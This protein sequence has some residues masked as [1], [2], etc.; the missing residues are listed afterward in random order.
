MIGD[1]ASSPTGRL[2]PGMDTALNPT[3][4]R[5]LALCRMDRTWVRGAGVWVWDAHG[6]RFL[7]C[8]AQYGAVALGHNAP[9]VVAAV[10]A[11]LDEG[12]PAMVQPYRAAHA[13][14][15]ADELARL[16]PGGLTRCLFTTSGAEAVE[17]AIQLVRARTGRPLVLSA[18]GSFHG[19]T[20]GALAASG[21]L[22]G[23]EGLGPLPPG[24]GRVPFGDA[25]ALA[26]RLER[27]GPRVAALLLEPIQG[28]R[29]VYLP[30]PGYLRAARDLCTRHGAALVLDE[31]QTGL[32]RTGKLFACEHEGV[33]PDVLLLSKALGGGLFPLGACLA[34]PA[35]WDEPFA[36][37]HSSTFAN[38]NVACRVGRAVL[39]ALT[40]GGLAAEAARKGKRLEDRLQELADRYPSVVA[41]A[42][43]RG[44]LGAIELRPVRPGQGTFLSFL[45]HQGLYAYAVAAAI[46]EIASVLVLPTLGRVPV[47]RV[48]PP[49][50]IGD[51]ELEQAVDGIEEVCRRLERNAP[52][53]LVRILGSTA[54]SGDPGEGAKVA[55]V[56]PPPPTRPAPEGP[57]YAFLV[58]PTRPG[59][60]ALTNPGLERLGPAELE[61][62]WGFLAQVPPG[63]VLRAPPVRSATGRVAHGWLILVPLLP[64]EMARRGLKS[65]SRQIAEAVDLA[66]CCGA[67]VV[68]LGGHTT[69]YSRRGLAVRGRGPAITT[70][71]ALTAGM[72]FAAVRQVAR[73][74][75]L[76][77]EEASVAVVG[78]R[79]S[80]GQ[81]CARLFARARPH[82]LLLVGNPATGTGPLEALREELAWGPNTVAVTTDPAPLAGC[83]I[84]VTATGAG[85]PVLDEAP[86]APGTIVCDV[87][88]PPDASARLRGRPD[89][90]VFD[91]G[92]VALPGPAVRFGA[93]NLQGLPKGV[94]LACLAETILRALEEDDRD[95]GIGESVP[96]AEVDEAMAAARRHG[97]RPAPLVCPRQPRVPAS[98]GRQ[99]PVLAT[100]G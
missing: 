70:G 76:H 82:R 49:L 81:L 91:G 74:R 79:G 94:Q 8:Y 36:L 89:L 54:E 6:R 50:V 24:F 32:G 90:L 3:R 59:D 84:V 73:R 10:R 78:A 80:V 62:V 26:R 67:R 20:L 2:T 97:F 85:V 56:L 86:L 98:G 75:H 31:I 34:S 77:L 66:K 16:A 57:A 61:R 42:R 46:A 27:D 21:R 4:Q 92:L 28:E 17:A 13:E 83:E 14:A 60:V 22:D 55:V 93:G 7:D 1:A 18:H 40:E 95:H 44:L 53:T 87:A 51:G 30:P 12:E 63:L 47:L 58:H 100:G 48:A 45:H 69:A 19:K 72:A 43:C 88:R 25:A 37:R 64:A 52:R 96:L 65:V 71:N 99:P 11:A 68:G 9:C 5:L 23:T 33:A 15:L 41:A 38:N 35:F 29:G 39:A